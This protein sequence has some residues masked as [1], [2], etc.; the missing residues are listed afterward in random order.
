MAVNWKQIG[1]Q[2][3]ASAERVL[4]GHKQLDR[5]L[6]RLSKAPANRVAKAGLRAGTGKA[7]RIMRKQLPSDLKHVRP[8]IG[9][10]VKTK[11][12]ETTAKAGAGVG[13]KMKPPEARKRR[14]VG[15]GARNIHWLVMGTKERHT[16]A[17]KSTG[18]MPPTDITSAVKASESTISSAIE[19][20]CEKQLAKEV[21][22]LGN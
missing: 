12:G 7:A 11:G 9:A 17:G 10:K 18:R 5:K 20:A 21:A 16:S 2:K 19:K 8:A 3:S 15:I 4:T 13:R 14:G 6:A 1:K 22:K